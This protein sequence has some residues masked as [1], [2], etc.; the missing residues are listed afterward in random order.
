MFHL[1]THP[2]PPSREG[3][4]T[5]LRVSQIIYSLILYPG[6]IPLPRGREGEGLLM[7]CSYVSVP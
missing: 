6:P 7:I 4:Q 2:N 3:T 5:S 1:K